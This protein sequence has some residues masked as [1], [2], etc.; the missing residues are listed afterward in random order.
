MSTVKAFRVRVAAD[1]PRK[2]AALIAFLSLVVQKMTDNNNFTSPGTVVTD[3]AGAV[4]AYQAA[5]KA[6]STSKDVGEA[7]TAAKQAMVDRVDQVRTYING[8]VALLP[9]DQATAAVQSAGFRSKKRS[10]NTKPPLAVKYGGTAGSVIIVALAAGHTAMYFFEYSKDQTNWVACPFV[11]KC[12]T[13]VSG[14]T[15]GTTYY[16]RFR[17]QT[18]KGLGADSM[19]VPFVVR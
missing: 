13:S 6:M 16:F 3:L 9:P 19:V 15:V 7:R 12:Q 1:L 4:A 5:L 14:L 10:L 2:D 8:V 17:A 18:R 11:M